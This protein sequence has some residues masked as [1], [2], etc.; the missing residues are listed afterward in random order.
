MGTCHNFNLWFQVGSCKLS[1][2]RPTTLGGQRKAHE[3]HSRLPGQ[4]RQTL[5]FCVLIDKQ[6]RTQKLA[7]LLIDLVTFQILSTL[8]L[9]WQ[10]LVCWEKRG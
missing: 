3:L 5:S 10:G 7:V 6:N 8:S 9:E 2:A 1:S 4:Q